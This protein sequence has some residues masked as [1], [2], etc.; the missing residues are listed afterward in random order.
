MILVGDLIAH[1][2]VFS[3]MLAVKVSG[4]DRGCS[5]G[6]YVVSRG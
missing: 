3:L 4:G 6:R 5:V 1:F 2:V